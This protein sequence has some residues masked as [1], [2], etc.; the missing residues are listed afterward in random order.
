MGDSKSSRMNMSMAA[1]TI[2]LCFCVALLEGFDIQALGISLGKLTT[3]FGL[4]GTQRTLPKAGA[5]VRS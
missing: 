1:K 4:D 3:E 5:H 2:A